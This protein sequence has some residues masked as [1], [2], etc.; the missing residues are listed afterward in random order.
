M[1]YKTRITVLAV[2]LPAYLWA[3]AQSVANDTLQIQRNKK[4]I[5]EFAKF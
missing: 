4:G 5:I 3:N 2:L 1:K